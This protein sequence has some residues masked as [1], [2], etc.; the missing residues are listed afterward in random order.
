MIVLLLTLQTCFSTVKAQTIRQVAKV[1]VRG[2]F[3]E[4]YF[5]GKGWSNANGADFTKS[6]YRRYTGTTFQRLKVETPGTLNLH[7]KAKV[8]KGL[9]KMLIVDEN[10]T[11]LAIRNMVADEE[12]F[13]D[14]DFPGAGNYFIKWAGIDTRGN[15]F[16][17]WGKTKG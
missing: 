17:E 12:N 8:K 14:I 2:T 7:Y 5:D 3:F 4:G 16:L 6:S 13:M 1:E 15:Y 11:V 10:N 9:L